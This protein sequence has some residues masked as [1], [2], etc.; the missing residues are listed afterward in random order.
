MF[1]CYVAYPYAFHMV[2]DGDWGF[3]M[4]NG[5]GLMPSP[6]AEQFAA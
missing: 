2:R 5:G 1:L 4:G 6:T 3:L